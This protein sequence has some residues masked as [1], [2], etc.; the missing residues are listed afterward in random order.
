MT[1]AAGDW[2]RRLKQSAEEGLQQNSSSHM[3]DVADPEKQQQ[4]PMVISQMAV[5]LMI[6]GPYGG[7]VSSL[8]L[9]LKYGDDRC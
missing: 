4:Q 3:T 6:E 7:T 1:Q 2:T 9:T 8:A 5:P